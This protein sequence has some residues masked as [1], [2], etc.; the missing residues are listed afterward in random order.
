MPSVASQI[1]PGEGEM[2]RLIRGMDWAATPL[3]PVERWPQSLRTAVS[4]CLGSRHPIVVWWGPERWMFYNDGYRPMLGESKHPQFLGASGRECW[5]EIWDVVGPMMDRVIATGEATWS[6]DL[7][8]LMNRSGYLEESYF[9][10]SYSPIRD[11]DGRPVGIFNACTETTARVLATRRMRTLRELTIEARST[12]EAA[13]SCTEILARNAQDIPFASIYLRDESNARLVLAAQAGLEAGTPACPESTPLDDAATSG[14][15]L[16]RVAATARTEHVRELASRFAGLPIAPWGVAPSEA[17]VL[18]IAQPGS[19]ERAGVLVLGINPRRAFDDEYQGFFG[20]VASHVATALS[21]ARAYQLER[22]RAEKLAEIDRLKTTFFS[23]VSHEF[24][25]PLTL[26]LG[27]IE[28]AVRNADKTLGGDSLET[29]RRN[30]VRLLELVNTLLDFSRAEAG[31]LD[32][33]FAPVELG[34]VTS[35]IASSFR[36]VVEAA[37]LAFV[38][39]CPPVSEPIYVD[40]TQWEK[41]V[42]NLISNAFKFTFHGEIRVELREH[43][44][45]IELAVRDT[46]TGIAAEHLPKI[47]ERFHRIDGA[48]GRSFEG[49]GIGLALVRDLVAL[50]GGSVRATSAVDH[51]SAFVVTL[52]R[53]R[54][55]LPADRI[56]ISAPAAAHDAASYLVEATRRVEPL[57][58]AVT[59]SA[60]DSARVLVVDDNADM[61][62]YLVR[63]LAPRWRVTAVEDGR[64]AL[65]HALSDPPDLV[66]SDVMMPRMTGVE[67]LQ[68]LRA[69]P[70]TNTIPIVLVSA[71]AGEE[72][73]VDGLETGADDYLVKPFSARELVSRVTTHLELARTRRAATKAALTLARTRAALLDDLERKNKELD[74]FNYAVSHDLRAPLR[75]IDGFSRALVEDFRTMLPPEARDFLGRIRSSAQRMAELIEDLLRLS[76]VTRADLNRDTIDVS[77][78][79]AGVLGELQR[80]NPERKVEIVVEPDVR[81]HADRQLLRITLENL[82]GNAW[83]YTAKTPVARI[84]FGARD[85]AI[86]V[87]DNGA[88]FD[89]RL[90]HRL[91]GAFQR[92]HSAAD[93]PG[94]GIGL[95]T[96]YRIIDRHGGQIWAEAEVGVGATFRFT[97][98]A[99]DDKT[100]T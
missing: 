99:S 83:K 75:S 13:R 1:F 7:Q 79:A 97:L 9:T 10:F 20:L 66:L 60:V 92:L 49:S 40:R 11:E 73:I 32:A 48:R 96:A 59:P 22:E 12:S 6:E 24:R 93:F 95:A 18:P 41:I 2:A 37:G 67:L 28:D 45:R 55:H 47:F 51:G 46:G 91:F 39:D 36:S 43:V 35:G 58:L 85:G 25:T 90:A 78:I 34:T 8:L 3:G 64:A 77:A 74:S 38:V 94:S 16:A 69:D 14:W 17:I 98:P 81:A 88:G 23:N 21:N 29:V 44:D 62:A 61:R 70:K 100:G 26:I 89:M 65:D 5:A 15:P 87:R 71:R 68:A 86:Y 63:L 42:L 27:P 33:R 30:A 54:A 72:A 84:E 52:P 82:L 31:K 80:A 50:H 57:A 4:I 53:G 76:R 56:V 19:A